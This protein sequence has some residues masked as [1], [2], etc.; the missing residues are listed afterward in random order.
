MIAQ[1]QSGTGKTAAFVLTMLSRVDAN[2]DYPQVCIYAITLLLVGS[3]T[4]SIFRW[5]IT[6]LN[7]KLFFFLTI[8]HTKVKEISL[9]YYLLIVGGRIIVCISLPRV[10]ALCEKPTASSKIWTE[11]AVRIHRLHLCRGLRHPHFPKSPW[12]DIK[13]SD[14]EAPVLEPWGMWSTPSLLSLPGPLW[15]GVVVSDR[16]L[17]MSQKKL[18]DHVTVCKQM[19]YAKLNY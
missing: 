16:V 17:S 4:R 13:Q 6:G 11:V 2:K 8:C 12:Y 3:N 1:S 7:S 18:F 15:P 10:L 19:T 9:P 14:D 5:N